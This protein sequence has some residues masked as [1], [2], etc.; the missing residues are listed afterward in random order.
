MIFIAKAD[1]TLEKVFPEAVNQGSVGVNKLILVAPFVAGTAVTAACKLPN[2]IYTKP[3]LLR[4]ATVPSLSPTEYGESYNAWEFTLDAAVTQYSGTVTVQFF[5]NGNGTV[6]ATY[7]D[8]FSVAKGVPQE[9]PDTP[10]ADVYND[11][12][13][14]LSG[15]GVRLTA[16]EETI[17]AHTAS[18]E[19]NKNSIDMQSAEISQLQGMYIDETTLEGGDKEYSLVFYDKTAGGVASHGKS[20]RVPLGRVSTIEADIKNINT[21]IGSDGATGTIKGRIKAVETKLATYGLFDDISITYDEYGEIKGIKLAFVENGAT[22]EVPIDLE[23]LIGTEELRTILEGLQTSIDGRISALNIIGGAKN[24]ISQKWDESKG[25]TFNFS[26]ETA[27]TKTIPQSAILGD[28]AAA[29]GGYSAATG[30]RA[31]ASGFTTWA[32]GD[33]SNASGL[34]TNAGG[35]ASHSEGAQSYAK[36]DYSHAEGYSTFANHDGAH[37]EGVKTSADYMGTH[38]EGIETVANFQ[39]AHAE[40]Y[41]CKA[42]GWI[43]HAEGNNCLAD[44]QSSHAEGK[45]TKALGD[46]AHSAGLGTT[47]TGK[48]QSVVGMYNRV[49]ANSLFLVG[50]G[51]SDF[52]RHDAFSINHDGSMTFGGVT[53][54]PEQFANAVGSKNYVLKTAQVVIPLAYFSSMLKGFRSYY[55]VSSGAPISVKANATT[56][57]VEFEDYTGQG[58]VE[59]PPDKIQSEGLYDYYMAFDML[60]LENTSPKRYSTSKMVVIHSIDSAKST[61]NATIY[62]VEE[63]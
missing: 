2:G 28:F 44:G 40:G 41:K 45:D 62:Y 39:A 9:L 5:V 37:A 20:I 50:N 59:F 38:A 55:T 10:S 52:D 17:V 4:T 25:N 60:F 56:G 7:A 11:I 47:A 16:A 21:V 22:K 1:G 34:Q 57:C 46:Y 6:L 27:G 54:T 15:A 36:G 51:T 8:T 42:S 48:A 13:D 19:A 30:K 35:Y 29:F 24:D 32:A 12:L 33:Y 63:A 26:S 61:A 14:A 53:V 3:T 43:S 58:L 31:F 49:A 23:E 18:I